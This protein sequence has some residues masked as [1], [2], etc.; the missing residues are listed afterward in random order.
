VNLAHLT[1]EDPDYP[2]R[3]RTLEA[4]PPTLTLHGS[5]ATAK[6][7]AIVGTRHPTPDAAAFARALAG[8]VVKSGAVVVSG[9]ALGIDAA[10][11]E[12]AL[13]HGGR[14]WVV[15]G[16]GHGVL[17]P[18]DHGPLFE[19]VVRGGGAVV[20]PFP[21]GTGAHRA[22][23][24]R[25]NAVLVALSDVLV[26]VQARIPSGALNAAAWAR[27]FGKPRWVVC[28]LP[29]NAND[30]DFAGC[31]L[32]R[33]AGARALTSIDDFLTAVDLPRPARL[34]APRVLRNPAETRVL[35]SISGKPRHVDEVVAQCGLPYP[36][37][38][39]LLLTLVLEDVLVEGPEGF[40]R[41]RT[42]P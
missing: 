27:R 8:A 41:E 39:T 37:V 6:T 35:A 13:D 33:K 5:L 4:P 7:V 25:R 2:A 19:R 36:E 22:R 16:T 40:F 12:G 3:L 20:W 14:T 28:P 26:I 38:V 24:L 17:Y 9:G 15:A 31:Q 32:E 21:P 11:H 30:A 1:L 23:F 10:A 34:P 29:W 18:K 42:P